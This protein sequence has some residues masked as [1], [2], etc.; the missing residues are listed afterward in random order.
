[1]R[2]MARRQSLIS[3]SSWASR[4]AR[5]GI[6][7]V[8][9]TLLFAH[10]QSAAGVNDHGELG[11][12]FGIA[13]NHVP[14]QLAGAGIEIQQ[15]DDRLFGILLQEF[16]AAVLLRDFEGVVRIHL[17]VVQVPGLRG[18]IVGAVIVLNAVVTAAM[19]IG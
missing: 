19:E 14:A 2:L 13:I 17:E 16:F 18:V 8:A 5:P 1:M 12:G 9:G 10:E 4:T 15:I 6:V 3:T 11:G 7:A